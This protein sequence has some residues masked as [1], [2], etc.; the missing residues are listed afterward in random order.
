MATVTDDPRLQKGDPCIPATT[1]V[2]AGGRIC[3]Q[4]VIY[5]APYWLAGHRIRV[6]KSKSGG[7]LGELDEPCD[8]PRANDPRNRYFLLRPLP[9]A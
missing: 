1:H 6:W 3:I 9:G 8:D 7:L 2:S 4:Q 5:A